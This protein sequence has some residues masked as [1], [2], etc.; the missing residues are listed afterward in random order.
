MSK[1]V[2]G[3]G[4]SSDP[5]LGCLYTGKECR[6]QA[7][8]FTWKASLQQLSPPLGLCRFHP[9][10]AKETVQWPAEQRRGPNTDGGSVLGIC[11]CPHPVV[12]RHLELG[13][14]LHELLLLLA[15]GEWREDVQEDFKQI[16]T[17]SR[18]TGQCEDGGD[19]AEGR[20]MDTNSVPNR[21]HTH[22]GGYR[23]AS[24]RLGTPFSLLIT[25]SQN[26][27]EMGHAWHSP[28]LR[29]PEQQQRSRL[30]WRWGNLDHKFP[31]APYW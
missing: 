11:P 29:S 18:H 28:D 30:L 27:R 31:P 1:T 13:Q 12:A 16:Q 8:P 6:R 26:P 7:G 14:L 10:E 17:L 22:P 15:V 25:P 20:G 19:T 3:A 2:S 23:S 9:P 4:G 5:G 21:A 24:Q